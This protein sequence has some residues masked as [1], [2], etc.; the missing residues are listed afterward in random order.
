MP[1]IDPRLPPMSDDSPTTPSAVPAFDLR[2][3][4]DERRGETMDLLREHVNP[5]F[6][7]VLKTIGFDRNY[8]R[9]KGAYLWDTSGRRYLDL[10]AGY[11]MF[12]L[13]RHHPVVQ[14]AIRQ[15]LELDEPTKPQMGPVLLSGLLAE[16][17]KCLAGAWADKVFFTNSGTESIEAALKFARASTKRHRV[18]YCERAFHGLTYGALSI[19]GCDS[20]RD[21]FM[22]LLPGMVSIPFGDLDAL[23]RELT[24]EKTAAFVVEPIQGKGVHVAPNEFL[25][26]AQELCRRHGAK[27]VVDEVQTGLGRT[28][29]M[30]AIDHVPGFEPDILTLSKALSGGYVPVGAVIMRQPVYDGVFTSMNRSV[31]HSSTFAQMGLA[32]TCGL[33]T[34][35]VLETERLCENAEAR[36]R[37][38]LTGLRELGARHELVA[39]VRGRGLMIA[40]E[41]AAPE[42][43][44][45]KLEWSLVHAADKSLMPQALVIPLL[46]DHGILTQVAGH[47]VD[48]VK[49]LPPLVLS[50]ED[51]QATIAAF[52]AT[53]EKVDQLAGSALLIAKKLARFSLLA[54]R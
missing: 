25:L 50:S 26:G 33:A 28:G 14:D 19:N 4:C 43:W 24:T 5:R 53:L 37:E 38:L 20:F 39:D 8:V 44:A 46:D 31:V 12:N 40:L 16:R 51:V 23:E 49:M 10:L 30:L 27:L 21:G 13:G 9:G 34:L 32:M 41:L 35:H 11:G 22:S 6:A 29:R 54:A 15:F 36:G 42:R 18:I 7:S 47:H 2:A 1:S 52:A 17:L 45:R 3:L 48:I